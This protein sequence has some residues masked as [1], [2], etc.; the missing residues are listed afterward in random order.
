M[1]FLRSALHFGAENLVS[2]EQMCVMLHR[3]T[4][5]L[6]HS[7]AQQVFESFLLWRR[8][9]DKGD[10][11]QCLARRRAQAAIQRKESEL[12]V[13][14]ADVFYRQNSHLQWSCVFNCFHFKHTNPT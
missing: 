9:E 5:L 12:C 3:D 11:W 13:C 14:V 7:G 1:S 2:I 4:P 8:M 10:V 6:D